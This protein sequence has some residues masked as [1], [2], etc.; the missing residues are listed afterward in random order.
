MHRGRQV[1]HHQWHSDT[2]IAVTKPQPSSMLLQAPPRKPILSILRTRHLPCHQWLLPLP[3]AW[4]L[5]AHSA[6]NTQTKTG[7][8]SQ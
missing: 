1:K 6:P 7:R 4:Q 8:K 3:F 2:A 5:S